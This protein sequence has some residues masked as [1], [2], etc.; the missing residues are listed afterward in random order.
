ME[1]IRE[2][3]KN[4]ECLQRVTQAVHI[5]KWEAIKMQWAQK[6]PDAQ[7]VLEALYN[8]QHELMVARDGC[9]LRDHRLVIP[10]ILAARVV[11]LAYVGHQGVGKT[12]SRMRNKV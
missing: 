9:I 3:V 5:G 2:A 7:K 12:K 8:V 1:E 10:S 4:D 11:Q 6:A